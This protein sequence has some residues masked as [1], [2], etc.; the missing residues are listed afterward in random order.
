MSLISINRVSKIILID[1]LL[2]VTDERS[3]GLNARTR[4]QVLR[5]DGEIEQARHLIVVAASKHSQDADKDLLETLEV[6]VLVNARVDDA[7][8]ENLLCLHCEEVTKVVHR[9]NLVWVTFIFSE[10]VRQ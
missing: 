5:L 1:R 4:L 3:D 9:V 2:G 10:E 8:V 6:P 7:R